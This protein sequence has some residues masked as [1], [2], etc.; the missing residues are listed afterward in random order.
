MLFVDDEIVGIQVA[1][2][3]ENEEHIT[4]EAW[5]H[6]LAIEQEEALDHSSED[7]HSGVHRGK[8]D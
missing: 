6:E 3:K 2:S 8:Y 4:D 5:N 1:D 7:E